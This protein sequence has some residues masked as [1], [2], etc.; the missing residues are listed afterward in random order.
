MLR[1]D[2]RLSRYREAGFFVRK[3]PIL[4]PEVV[5]RVGYG[6]IGQ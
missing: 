3:N 5:Y 1:I 6:K 2:K 4:R